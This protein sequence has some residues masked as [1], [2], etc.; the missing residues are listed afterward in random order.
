MDKVL[1]LQLRAKNSCW[2]KSFAWTMD[3]A[4][5][6]LRKHYMATV[7]LLVSS[8]SI[9]QPA[10]EAQVA[11]DFNRGKSNGV[12]DLSASYRVFMDTSAIIP[13]HQNS[14]NLMLQAFLWLSPRFSMRLGVGSGLPV[15]APE[16]VEEKAS[17][18]L[19]FYEGDFSLRFTLL[20]ADSIII[21]MGALLDAS[22]GHTN[23]FWAFSAQSQNAY[24][25][26]GLGVET[27]IAFALA[28]NYLFYLRLNVL[29]LTFNIIE[30]QDPAWAFYPGQASLEF[31]FLFH[32]GPSFRLSKAARKF[33]FGPFYRFEMRLLELSP[34]PEPLLSHTIGLT[35]YAKP[36]F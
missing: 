17:R 11:I 32:K 24:L 6:P 2:A 3:I 25:Q 22:E 27:E 20:K 9:A 23:T 5:G 29:F 18:F 34:N 30:Q 1:Y 14:L 15:F 4:Q 28:L 19:F 36:P 31:A 26:A 12:I 21:L 33:Y 35:Y 7:F 10:I 16:A 8:I 13:K